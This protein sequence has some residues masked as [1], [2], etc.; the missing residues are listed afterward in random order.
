MSEGRRAKSE[1]PKEVKGARLKG[2][3]GLKA[4]RPKPEEVKGER[5]KAKGALGELKAESIKRKA[6]VKSESEELRTE[7]S[8]LQTENMEVHHHPQLEHKPKPWKEYLLEY[9]MIF[10][11][12][13]TGFFAESYREHLSEHSKEHEYAVN[14]KKDMAADIV[15]LD[16]WVPSLYQ[17]MS[18]IDTLIAFLNMPG[19]VKNGSDM[20]YYARI[21]TKVGIFEPS[22]NTILEL[23]S[24]GN[25]RLIRGSGI[26][27]GLMNFE[28]IIAQYKNI[29]EIDHNEDMLSYPLLG[30]LFD[31]TVFD[32]MV[33]TKLLQAYAEKDYAVGSKKYVQKPSGNP[34][35]ISHDKEKINMLIFYLHQRKSSFLG[36]IRQLKEQKKD[37]VELIKLINKEYDLNDE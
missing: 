19:Q 37:A 30:Q 13:M 29:L 36:E 1:V 31:A 3:G 11:A 24:S 16:I 28:R 32:K 33:N 21:S 9:L 26:T 5:I 10:L 25:L 34:Q 17:R 22:D 7:N 14:I 2:K 35:L 18:D 15:N 8:K 27:N 4:E 12:V 6:E 20:Y 23:K